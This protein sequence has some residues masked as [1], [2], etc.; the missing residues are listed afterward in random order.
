VKRRSRGVQDWET[1][2]DGAPMP[3]GFDTDAGHAYGKGRSRPAQTGGGPT[4][5]IARFRPRVSFARLQR[6]ASEGGESERTPREDGGPGAA[7]DEEFGI[8]INNV[9]RTTGSR[10]GSVA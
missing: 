3:A 2:A 6:R 4:V 10:R 5:A 1:S 8:G 9:Q 7:I